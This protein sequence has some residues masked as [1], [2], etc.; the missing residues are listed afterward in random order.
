MSALYFLDLAGSK[1]F[2]LYPLLRFFMSSSSSELPWRVYE[3]GVFWRNR[4][5]PFQ[6]SKNLKKITYEPHCCRG[7]FSQKRLNSPWCNR[8]H[9]AVATFLHR[10]VFKTAQ[11][12]EWHVDEDRRTLRHMTRGRVL[13]VEA[14]LYDG[15]RMQIFNVHQATSGDVQLQQHTWQI[16]AKSVAE[17]KHHCILLGGD[18]TRMPMVPG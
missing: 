9:F 11:R 10:E 5:F 3:K 18:P 15:Q 1:C 2:P 7:N 4:S 12:R 8:G 6:I 14:E 17:C 16:L 13:R